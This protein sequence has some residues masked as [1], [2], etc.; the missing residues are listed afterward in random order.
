M[1]LDAPSKAAPATRE[2]RVLPPLVAAQIAAGEVVERPASI[3]KELVDNALDA[4]A[5]SI[6]IELEQGGIE[7][8]R[9]TDDGHGVPMAQVP[10]M[11]APHATSKV[12]TADDLDR[13]TTMGFRGE[14]LASIASVSRLTIR[15]RTPSDLGAHRLD[16]EG[17]TAGEARPES[18]PVGTS[19]SVRNLF[20]NTPA[21]RK[22][23]RTPAT[24]QGH[25]AD[26]A[27]DLAMAHPHVGFTLRIDGR[28]SLEL[29]PN[30]SPLDRALDLLGREMQSQYLHA[31]ADR[32]DDVRG[33]A[34]WGLVGTPALA[35]PTPRSQHVFINGR[36]VRD[37][38][39]QHALKE[40]YRGLI[41]PGRHPA[42]VIQIAM[43]PGA[44]D[45]NVHPTKAEVRFRDPSVVHQSVY[46]AAREALR[47]AD[48]TPSVTMPALGGAGPAG[49]IP[50]TPV[51]EG[52][53]RPSAPSPQTRP[54]PAARFVAYFQR[55]APAAAGRFEYAPMRSA[56]VNAPAAA[57]PLDQGQP[58]EGA[59][60]TGPGTPPD[61]HADQTPAL[62]PPVPAERAL[63]VHNSYLVTQDEHGVIIIDQHALHERVMFEKLRARVGAGE[64][65]SQRLLLPAVVGASPAAVE[66]LEGLT[67]VLKRLGV[68]AEPIGP[69]SVAVH[70]F[71]SFL[72]SKK[73]DPAEFIGELLER[74]GAEPTSPEALNPAT[75]EEDLL[76]EVLDMMACKAAIKAG[77]SLADDE[78]AELLRLRTEVERASN[79]PHGRPTAIRLSIRDL[80]KSFGRA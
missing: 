80:E 61:G 76:H 6:T 47:K 41:E 7:L 18:G 46:H 55:A 51:G 20:F 77:D 32:F 4:G 31:S 67:P 29:P 57:G 75:R 48:L 37:K 15:S 63:Q 5:T 13:I 38:T 39:I 11:V 14:A 3:V 70:A 68:T 34:L 9:V 72:I 53:E 65:E 36:P 28:T 40:A 52:W 21:R 23:L 73:V 22:F 74:A 16:V 45:V 66:R 60:A 2:I 27:R 78:I 59:S 35:R 33:V 64:L 30:Q 10:L 58:L 44:V 12:R 25:C 54:L 26:I 1:S 50:L 24:E 43:D 17:L 19:V 79:C 69:A 62:A 42:A 71:P 8:V 56:V 49:A